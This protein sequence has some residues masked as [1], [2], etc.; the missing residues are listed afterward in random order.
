MATHAYVTKHRIA[1]FYVLE[2]YLDVTIP[3]IPFS[4]LFFHSYYVLR[5][6]FL[7]DLVL[8]HSFAQLYCSTLLHELLTSYLPIRK[9]IFKIFLFLFSYTLQWTLLYMYICEFPEGF[10]QCYT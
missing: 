7:L 9:L 8:G 5:V 4:S 3:C 6:S 1:C 2:M 10:P